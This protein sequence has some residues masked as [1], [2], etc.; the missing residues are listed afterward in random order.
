MAKR[1][2]GSGPGRKP[3]AGY[4]DVKA[5]RRHPT[6]ATQGFEFSDDSDASEVDRITSRDLYRLRVLPPIHRYPS[7]FPL[8][9]QI[10]SEERRTARLDDLH[11]RRSRALEGAADF[12]PFRAPQIGPRQRA[13][14]ARRTPLLRRPYERSGRFW[15]ALNVIPVVSPRRVWFCVKRKLRREVLFAFRVAGLNRRRSPGGAGGYKRTLESGL[16]C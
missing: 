7:L 2:R 6:P 11:R 16:K 15:S 12:L 9:E 3:G 13:R 1:R 8:A 4:D 14:A 5:V 10:L